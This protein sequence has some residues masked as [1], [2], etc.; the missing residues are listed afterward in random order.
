MIKTNKKRLLIADDFEFNRL[1]IKKI[2][3]KSPYN[4]TL[5][6]NGQEAVQKFSS[7]PFDLVILDI[8]MPVMDGIDA[9]K[10]MKEINNHIPIMALTG[11]SEEARLDVLKQ[12]GFSAIIKKPFQQGD[13]IRAIKQ[14]FKKKEDDLKANENHKPE[15]SKITHKPEKVYDLKLLEEFSAGDDSFK[16]EMLQYFVQNSPAVIKELKE[17]FWQND[18][19]GIRLTAHKY[20]SELGFIGIASLKELCDRIEKL[21]SERKDKTLMEKLLSDMENSVTFVV[22]ELIND[23]NLSQNIN[24]NLSL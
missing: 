6:A 3:D 20:G 13:F 12:L 4:F 23:F 10:K 14:E 24:E 9:L 22:R 5:V 1:L 18:W 21:A 8:E 16:I 7:E 2:L 17:R 19:E 15:A 11:H